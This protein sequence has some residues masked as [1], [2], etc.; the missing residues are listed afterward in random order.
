MLVNLLLCAPLY[1]LYHP[2]NKGA[3]NSTQRISIQLF[4]DGFRK[5]LTPNVGLLR[6][7]LISFLFVSLDTDLFMRSSLER[8][9]LKMTVKTAAEPA[10]GSTANSFPRITVL[11]IKIILGDLDNLH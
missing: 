4:R 5:T 11:E 6:D 7:D 8:I 9:I 2:R 1:C 10:C 3:L